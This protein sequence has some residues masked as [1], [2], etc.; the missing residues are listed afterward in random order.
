MSVSHHYNLFCKAV[1]GA[2]V[3]LWWRGSKKISKELLN[4]NTEYEM[5]LQKV[6]ITYFQANALDGIAFVHLN[7]PDIF[8]TQI[9]F[10]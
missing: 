8:Q 9:K 3:G 6:H 4:R 7:R 1:L 2:N 5:A 10:S